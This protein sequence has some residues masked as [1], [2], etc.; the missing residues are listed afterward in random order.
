MKRSFHIYALI[1]AFSILLSAC[2]LSEENHNKLTE[3]IN[4]L[5]TQKEFAEEM[6][7]KLTTD[8]YEGELSDLASKY[9]EYKSMDIS[10][11]SDKEAPDTLNQI[12]ELTSSYKSVFDKMDAELK[13]EESISNEAAKHIEILCRIENKSDSEITSIVLKDAQTSSE[14]GNFILE[15]HSLSSGEILE[16]VVLPIYTD[17]ASRSLLVT[18]ASGETAEYALELGDVNAASQ[19]GISVTIGSSEEGIII[20]DYSVTASEGSSN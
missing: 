18:D 17:S 16:G 4:E 3:A 8:S 11:L 9:E 13:N 2:G 10:K 5:T 12:S 14:S 20:G 1:A 7:G 6:Y 19:N 15:G